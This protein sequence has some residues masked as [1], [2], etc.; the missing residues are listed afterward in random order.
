MKRCKRSESSL[1][2]EV[3]RLNIKVE[4]EQREHV[5]SFEQEKGTW[6]SRLD[7]SNRNW[8]ESQRVAREISARLS[9]A[10]DR[11]AV[12]K[13]AAEGRSREMMARESAL[14]ELHKTYNLQP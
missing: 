6:S 3:K 7:D 1:K 8:E 2:E 12:L 14:E 10:E 4:N 5:R 9:D 11:E 13:A